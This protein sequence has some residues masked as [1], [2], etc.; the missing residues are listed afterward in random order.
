MLRNGVGR[1]TAIVV[2]VVFQIEALDDE[3]AILLPKQA[4]NKHYEH[5]GRE[6]CQGYIFVAHFQSPRLFSK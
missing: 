2:A 5:H 3:M 1:F 6:C 4:A